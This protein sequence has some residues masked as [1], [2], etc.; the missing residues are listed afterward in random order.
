MRFKKF[1]KRKNNQS[2]CILFNKFKGLT[3]MKHKVFL[4]AFA[5]SLGLQATISAQQPI[6]FVPSISDKGVSIRS[7]D[8]DFEFKFKGLLQANYKA[9]IEGLDN[10][11]DNFYIRR[12]RTDFRTTFYK[13]LETRLHSEWG[14]GAG[15]LL[16]GYIGLKVSDALTIR[17]GKDKSFLGIER[18]QSPSD[19]AFPELGLP[20]NL[21]PNRDLGIGAYGSFL[22]KKLEYNVGIYNGVLDL[23][24]V[25]TDADSGKDLEGRLFYLPVKNVGFG[26]TASYGDRAGTTTGTLLP[27]YK[28]PGQST[29]FK[30]AS[31]TF[32]H[33]V[34]Y[35]WSPQGYWYYGPWG[36][37]GEY[38]VSS[39]AIQKGA[40]DERI[41]NNAWGLTFNYVWTGETRTF[42]GGVKP[43]QNFNREKGT[44]GALETV[45]RINQL[46]VDNDAFDGYADANSYKRATAVGLGLN[47]FP[48]PISKITVA[49]E[50]TFLD[51]QSGKQD[52]ETVLIIQNQLAF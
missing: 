32:A 17:A 9:N 39:Q 51:K 13:V 2:Q 22:N 42:V 6:T 24:N 46:T 41:D 26:A 31:N 27:T 10:T 15:T 37:F 1:L 49:I 43:K 40:N 18:H 29:L 28:T 16:D 20:T 11:K 7:T 14:T 25:D 38:I 48:F 34:H 4:S 30:Y 8:G 35:R 52:E 3:T 50:K 23:G 5:L 21:V 33:G 47:W 12:F 19:I 36:I 44:W 45:L